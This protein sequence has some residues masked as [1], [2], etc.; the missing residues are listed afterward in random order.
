[1]P[2]L[3]FPL[4][5]L[6]LAS[7]ALAQTDRQVW[8]QAVFSTKLA[9][10]TRFFG[11]LQPRLGEDRR[12]SQQFLARAAF[13]RDL[14]R[15]FTLWAGYAWTPNIAPDFRSEDRYFLQGSATTRLGRFT[16][17]NRTRLEARN[18][19]DAFGT[20]VRLRHQLR[21]DVPLRAGS[22]I[23]LIVWD[24]YFTNLNSTPRGPRPG[25]DQNRLF[26][27]FGIPATKR[28]RYEIGYQRVDARAERHLD[29]LLASLF[30][31]F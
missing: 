5:L 21:A 31:N 18:I 9:N 11:E 12:S 15:E 26:L 4:V 7:G 20:S 23:R 1:M 10:G 25:F 29:T 8:L 19:D 13:G 3:A 27:G 22:P 17:G 28:T 14:G 6:T 24:E 30:V 16:I 2:R